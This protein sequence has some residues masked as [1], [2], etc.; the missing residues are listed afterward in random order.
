[1][2]VRVLLPPSRSSVYKDNLTPA[3]A[4]THGG[5]ECAQMLFGTVRCCY[6]KSKC[7]AQSDVVCLHV[8]MRLRACSRVSFVAVVHAEEHFG[9]RGTVNIECT[10]MPANQSYRFRLP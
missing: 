7:K 3:N 2:N 8:C 1:M 5:F 10:T 9:D 4:V 6:L